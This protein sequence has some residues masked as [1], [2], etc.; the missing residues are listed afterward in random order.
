MTSSLVKQAARAQAAV[1]R[2]GLFASLSASEWAATIEDFDGK[3]AYCDRPYWTLDH[4]IPMVAGGPSWVGNC[5][6]SCQT[7]NNSKGRLTPRYVFFVPKKRIEQIRY[8]LER[9]QHGFRSWPPPVELAIHEELEALSTTPQ[10]KGLG[11]S[12]DG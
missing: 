11:S 3:C 6:P 9:R 8:Y 5:V 7:C 10:K 1:R 4:F 12:R 2:R